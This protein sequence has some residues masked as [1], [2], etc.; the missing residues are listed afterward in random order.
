MGFI[1]NG[2][3]KV[4]KFASEKIT[5]SMK[6]EA[7]DF[8]KDNW[9]AIAIGTGIGIL[10]CVTGYHFGCKGAAK[11]IHECPLVTKNYFILTDKAEEIVKEIV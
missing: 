8:L 4:K 5:D 10:T 1:K 6:Q 3:D 7:K 2:V 9:K 11:K